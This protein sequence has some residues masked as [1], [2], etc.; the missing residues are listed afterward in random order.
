VPILSFD[1]ELLWP[2]G[3]GRLVGLP[4]VRGRCPQ[5]CT[6]C[7]L[8]S[9]RLYPTLQASLQDQLEAQLPL[10]L[11]HRVPLYLPEHFTGPKPL[12]A[13]AAALEAAGGRA[14]V[15]LVDVH[16]RMI[17][18][19]AVDAL[20]RIA[21]RA[22]RLRVWLGVESGAEAVRARAGRPLADG[23]VLGAFDRLAAAGIEGL[24]ASMMVGLPGE[25]VEDV[26]ASDAL[27]A[28]LNAR[29]I[30]ANVLPVVAFPETALY[31]DPG[32]FGVRLRMRT[33]LDFERL[34]RGW[35]LP[36]EEGAI[37][38]ESDALSAG[39]RVEATLKLRLRQRERLGYRTT[40]E[41]FRT[42]EHLP[43]LRVPGDCETMLARYAPLLASPRFGG[44]V[45][46]TRIW[47]AEIA[48]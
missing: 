30:L 2:P 22:D 20:A 12:E 29:G 42:M 27:I 16:P 19:R 45:T 37:S 14:S 36:I 41:L 21:A 1:P 13:L 28:R 7:S 6:Y 3:R 26:M 15:V 35:H 5:P 48:P 23:D 38:M 17:R 10:F 34:S 24:Q 18:A 8:N 44:A 25:R 33:P 40:P 39:E 32:A 47:S 43:G 4:F 9:E 31:R 46:P 11:S